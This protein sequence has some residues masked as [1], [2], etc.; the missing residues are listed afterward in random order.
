MA[1]RRTL[2]NASFAVKLDDD[3]LHPRLVSALAEI[4]GA[5]EDLDGVERL[6]NSAVNHSWWKVV[7]G[8]HHVALIWKP[9]G[10]RCAMIHEVDVVKGGLA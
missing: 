4:A 2:L 3:A 5:S 9:S 7:R 8:G 6:V 10:S 1:I